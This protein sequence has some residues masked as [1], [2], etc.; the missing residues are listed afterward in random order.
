MDPTVRERYDLR[1]GPRFYFAFPSVTPTAACMRLRAARQRDRIREGHDSQRIV[2]SAR[3]C[4]RSFPVRRVCC[5]H[6]NKTSGSSSR[7]NFGLG[8][9]SVRKLTYL[10]EG[11]VDSTDTWSWDGR[12][13]RQVSYFGP[14]RRIG[15]SMTSDT[16][17]SCTVLFGGEP[18]AGQALRDTWVFDG[19]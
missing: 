7:S 13:W 17:R 10:F 1:S 12:C 18:V 14:T 6:R 5:G 2:L 3:H 15:H 11:S 4:L 16:A 19:T 9:D 8:Y